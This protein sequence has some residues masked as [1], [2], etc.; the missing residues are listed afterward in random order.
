MQTFD[1]LDRNLELNRHYLLEASAGTG[2]TFS[3]QN[4]VVRLLIAENPLPINK[5]LVVTFTRAATRE[6]KKRI[7]LSIEQSIADL[8]NFLISGDLRDGVP[9]Y[10]LACI[11]QGQKKIE[12]AKR[13]LTLALI[14]FDQAQIFTIHG[15]CSRML[16]Q[17]A[18]DSNIGLQGYKNEITAPQAEFKKIVLDYFRTEIREG[19]F[20]PAQLEIVLKNDPD[21]KELIKTLASPHEIASY[22][23]FIEQF[24]TFTKIMDSLKNKFHL[25]SE[26]VMADFFAQFDS[27]KKSEKHSGKKDE[28]IPLVERFASLFDQTSW[29]KADLDTLITDGLVWTM[30]FDP[31]NLK[32][33]KTLN[34]IH[35]HFPDLTIELNKKLESLILEASSFPH[36]LARM[37]K[38]CQALFK[39]YQENE[40]RLFPDDIL[41]KMEAATES[42]HFLKAVQ[43]TYQAA[44]IDEFQDTD[45]LQWNI[46]KRLF[47]PEDNSWNGTLTLVGDPKQSI[48]S[49]R[50]ADIYTYLSAVHAM[51]SKAH[52]SLD[53]NFRSHPHLV[54][55]LN[56]L[57]ASERIP[58]LIPLPKK[59]ISLPYNPVKS[60]SKPQD[61]VIDDGKGSVHFFIADGVHKQSVKMLTEQVFYPFIAS[62]IHRLQSQERLPLSSFAILVKSKY[63]AKGLS[64]FLNK[65]GIAVV[66]QS[67]PHLADSPIFTPFVDFLRAALNP[68]DLSA[69]KSALGSILIGWNADDFKIVDSIEKVQI[70]L[71]SLRTLWKEK[72]FSLFFNEAL[73]TIWKLVHCSLIERL[74]SIEDGQELYNDLI[75]IADL[76]I[77]KQG[78]EWLS[79]ERL[80]PFLSDLK[81]AHDNDENEI[82]SIQNPGREGVKIITTHYSKGLEF[83]IVFALGLSNP[84]PKKQVLIPV[85]KEGRISMVATSNDEELQPFET[86]LDAEKLRQ[87]YVAMTR[88]RTRLYVSLAINA[89]DPKANEGPSPL[90]LFINGWGLESFLN[91]LKNEGPHH[92]ITHSF[93][94]CLEE[95]RSSQENEKNYLELLPPPS[96]IAIPGR[97]K[98]LN[99]FTSLIKP[100]SHR[101]DIDA[102][103]SASVKTIHTLP[104]GKETGIALHSILENIVFEEARHFSTNQ[105][106]YPFITPYTSKTALEGWEEVICELIFKVIRHST[107]SSLH[108][109][110]IYR[111]MPFLFPDTTHSI[112]PETES[113]DGYI[114]G[115]ID[116]IFENNGRYYILDWKS[117]WLGQSNEAYEPENLQLAMENENYFLQAKIYTEALKRYL[118]IIDPRPFEEI[119]GGALYFFLRGIDQPNGNGIYV[120]KGAS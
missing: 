70:Q 96:F 87:L 118:S 55:A 102:P 23:S 107:L 67:T 73:H 81:I 12:K 35:L 19:I 24:E 66:R 93:A 29:N 101:M 72:G 111:E 17:Y 4:I 63:Q 109:E 103:K 85:E 48:Y 39:R 47:L 9:D 110:N 117:N 62:E 34:E 82:K 37:A 59:Q 43:S 86:E 49:F 25:T 15:F 68:R 106:L 44:I 94:T 95:K 57:F 69:V 22:N 7:R 53:T 65:Q 100:H 54:H 79:S 28:I 52:Y 16:K 64:E 27:Y 50:Q 20:S 30:I 83:D 108:S 51:G 2:K 61:K 32:K 3:I 98:I 114:K 84:S 119:F 116:L 31:S 42:P 40:E 13:Q 77:E 14:L 41:K 5:I 76:I 75:Q 21:Q 115:V 1:V 38:D 120:V 105:D 18:L 97:S 88:A 45:P 90:S 92:H 71:F 89:K 10:L 80:I 6:L 112:I 46:F 58:G 74:L 91:F 60:V 113:C 99:S 78:T 36:L 8:S 56:T 26:K 104:L 33:K 11:E